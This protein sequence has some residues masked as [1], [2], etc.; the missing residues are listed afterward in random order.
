MILYSLYKNIPKSTRKLVE[1]MKALGHIFM[2]VGNS[3]F[4]SYSLVYQHSTGG[5]ATQRWP[6]SPAPTSF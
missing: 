5:A 4:V 2:T 6:G 1:F 3:K